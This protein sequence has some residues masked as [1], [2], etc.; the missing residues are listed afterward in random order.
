MQSG[1]WQEEQQ[2]WSLGDK[3]SFGKAGLK[4]KMTVEANLY[5]YIR[6]IIN[7]KMMRNIRM[8][9]IFQLGKVV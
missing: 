8:C 7:F 5:N 3:P 1:R 4:A 2:E 9:K 6:S